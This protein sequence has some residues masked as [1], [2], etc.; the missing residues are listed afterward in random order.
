MV[1]EALMVSLKNQILWCLR[2]QLSLG[3]LLL[4][5]GTSFYFAGYRPTTNRI[6]A[7]DA[8]IHNMQRE[9][10]ENS[11]LSQ[12]LDS[13][14]KEVKNLRLKLDGSKKLPK[15]VDVA[16]FVTDI[17]RISQATQLRKPDYHPD[18]AGPKR[19]ELFSIY[20]IRLQLQGNFTNVFSFIRQ[21]EALPRLSR[22]RSIN[23]KADEKAPGKVIVNLGMDLY[24]TPDM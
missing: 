20:Q 13:V 2:A 15:E 8:D 3:G 9:V 4:A 19:G 6:A 18:E 7:L 21:A 12:I 1:D 11:A 23:I 24:F 16:A 17:L 22:V 5:I 14:V 10:A